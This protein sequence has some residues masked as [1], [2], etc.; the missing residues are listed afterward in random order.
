MQLT[1]TQFLRAFFLLVSIPSL[2]A[3]YAAYYYSEYATVG[4]VVFTAWNAIG[5]YC[6]RYLKVVKDP[7]PR[8]KYRVENEV[9]EA[10]AKDEG[11]V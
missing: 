6:S 3:G 2:A 8:E 9:D 7:D 5:I 4:V 1:S 10:I 11:L